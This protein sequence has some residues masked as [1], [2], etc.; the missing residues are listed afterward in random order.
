MVSPT[1]EVYL[2]DIPL[3]YP[4]KHRGEAVKADYGRRGNVE[5]NS[6]YYSSYSSKFKVK[7]WNVQKC[8]LIKLFFF[9]KSV[10]LCNESLNG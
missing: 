2:W 4:E 6:F 8:N 5:L 7:L 9:L 3:G 10:F 1:V